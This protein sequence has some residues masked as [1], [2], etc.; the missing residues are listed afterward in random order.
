M[1]G[2]NN[3]FYQDDLADDCT[4]YRLNLMIDITSFTNDITRFTDEMF[5]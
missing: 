5:N 1:A 3:K 4:D 2:N